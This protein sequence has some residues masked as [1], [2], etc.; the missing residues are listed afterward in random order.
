M[1][2]FFYYILNIADKM[3]LCFK[4]IAFSRLVE[5]EKGVKFFSKSKVFN[6]GGKKSNI[7]IGKYTSVKGELLTF[8][9]GGVITIGE[10]CYIGDM[11]RIWSACRI[12]IGNRVLIAHNVNIH[13]N[14]SHPLN[15]EERHEQYK[16]IISTGHPK[17]YFVLN[18]RPI[19]IEDDVWIGFNSTILKGVKIGKGAIIGACSVV[20]KDVASFTI[21][22]GNPAK[23]IKKIN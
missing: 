15:A 22:A 14:N 19:I 3:L 4:T 8:R 9:H 23:E 18:E 12:T 10:Y 21:V 11:T 2:K 17:E 5:C 6:I 16:K 7:R 13:D 1:G 20:T